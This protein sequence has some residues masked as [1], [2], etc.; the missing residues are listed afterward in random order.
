MEDL[1]TEAHAAERGIIKGLRNPDSY[2]LSTVAANPKTGAICLE[3]LAQNGFGGMNVG[4]VAFRK[5]DTEMLGEN[6]KGF[7]II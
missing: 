5:G 4:R 1:R 3:Y 7:T 6:S 2:K